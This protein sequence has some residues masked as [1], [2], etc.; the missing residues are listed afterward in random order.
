M[1]GV[2]PKMWIG[3]VRLHTAHQEPPRKR[4]AATVADRVAERVQRRWLADDAVVE[5]L[6]A[7]LQ[8]LDDPHR[9]VDRG[10]F[11]VGGQQEGD[12]A[13]VR[14]ALG[15][16]SLHSDDERSDRGL[17]VGAPTAEQPAVALGRY[18]R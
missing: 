12:R 13:G 11:F 15:D 1:N 17:H 6:A 10:T 5:P 3:N 2:P 9:A 4:S 7:R 18:E 8:P 16:E 14:R